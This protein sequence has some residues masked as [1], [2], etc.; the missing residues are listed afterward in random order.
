VH[1]TLLDIVARMSGRIFVG[2]KLSKR[3]LWYRTAVDFATCVFLASGYLKILPS[4]VRPL[5]AP[6]SPHLWRIKKYYRNW[7]RLLHPEIEKRTHNGRLVPLQ[8]EDANMID[9]IIEASGEKANEQDI[10]N[11]SMGIGFAAIHTTTNHMTNVLFD[12]AAR[13]DEY[14]PE[15]VAEYKQALKEEGGVMT[16][17][18]VAKLSK[19][20]SFMKESQRCS[21]PSSCKFTRHTPVQQYFR[22]EYGTN[23]Y[24]VAF[25]R[26]VLQQHVLSDGTIL[27][28]SCWI[29]VASGPLMQDAS[30]FSNPSTFD[31]FRYHRM[32]QEDSSLA[33][34]KT[35]QFTSTGVY[36]L[37]FGHGRYACPGRFFAGLE[38]KLMMVYILEHYEFRLPPGASRPK[39]IVYAD[40]LVPDPKA[41][42]EFRKLVK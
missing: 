32:R 22:C 37:V 4:F 10:L 9:W 19:M 33:V 5:V 3:R 11:R 26:K 34:A 20:D 2:D 27:P 29:A 25:N 15:I 16:K 23:S 36:S 40:A 39:N 1:D 28:K 42:L 41:C 30:Q 18:V 31:G 35:S 7:K 8:G 12:L 13:W 14:G 38:A 17:N 21:P 6:F 24:A